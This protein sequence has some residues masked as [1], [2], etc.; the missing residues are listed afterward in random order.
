MATK[1]WIV[2]LLSAAMISVFAGC[3]GGTTNVENAQVA[4]GSTL[5]ITF[6]PAPVKSVSIITT[7][8]LTAVV[9]NDPGNLGVDWSLTCQGNT[10]CGSLSPLHTASGKAATY[11]PPAGLS[12][13]QQTV[14]I[15]AFATADHTRNIVTPMTVTAFGSAL[16]GRYVLHTE[17]V[18]GTGLA[19]QF[20]GVIVLDG[21]G[22]V[23]SGEQT[24]SNSLLS[25]SDPIIGG[26][27]FLGPDGRGKLSLHTK[28]KNLGQQGLE[29]FSLV[30]LSTSQALIAK[31]DDPNIQLTSNESSA[32][33]MDLQTSVTAPAHGYAFVVSGT[34]FVV[35]NNFIAQV[36]TGTGGV[37]NIDSPNT[38]SG[39]GSIADQDLGGSVTYSAAISGTV[40]NPD[41]FGAVKFNLTAGFSSTPLQFTGYVVDATHIQ[42]IETDVDATDGTGASTGG[43]A[44]GQGTATGTFTNNTALAGPFV[45]SILGQDPSGLATSLA[46]AGVFI[47]NGKGYLEH[48]F[49]DEFGLST[50]ISDGFHGR[51]TVD[52]TG[53]GRVDSFINYFTNGP[54]PEFIFYLTGNGNPPLVLDADVNYG[55]VG[56]GMAYPASPQISFTG[57]YGMSFTQNNGL[58]DDATG[59]VT[60]DGTAQTLSGTVDTNYVFAPAWD[61]P[62]TG[63]FQPSGIHHFP[64]ILSNQFFPSD[65][66]MAFY[67]IDAGHG[68]FVETDSVQVSFGYFAARTPVCQGCP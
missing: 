64:G 37:L 66:T 40:S 8:Q 29:T 55:C 46:S 56:G 6:Q 19:Y 36:P 43:I 14:N 41:S 16:K 26:S 23:T 67:I 42:L 65:L 5:S 9:G 51:Y 58:E 44:V 68:F 50:Q 24:Y 25:T 20:A 47:A 18:D 10:N 11:T 12:T 13:N 32:G 63:T 57:K 34:G 39:A 3:G 15:A 59:P 35:S 21:K 61:T 62:L 52:S 48:G 27:Y 53:T 31:I 1:K 28:N 17:G 4:V 30:F 54:G 38:I 33:S 45:F 2:L 7:A 60:V 22:G 49:N